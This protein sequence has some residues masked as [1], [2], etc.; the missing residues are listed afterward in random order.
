MTSPNPAIL[1]TTVAI[2]HE[3]E[4]Y[5]HASAFFV[6]HAEDSSGATVCAVAVID[7]RSRSCG[8]AV[9]AANLAATK[10]CQFHGVDRRLLVDVAPGT[11]CLDFGHPSN[12]EF[13]G[14]AAQ[15]TGADS[16]CSGRRA[17]S[18]RA[19]FTRRSG[20]ILDQSSGGFTND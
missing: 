19:R 10:Q 3:P 18:D 9:V 8:H 17:T 16:V 13:G 2:S 20:T 6:R 7:L 12:T 5:S 14:N 4:N 11:R 15:V 1:S